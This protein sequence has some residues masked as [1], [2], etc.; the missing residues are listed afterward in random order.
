MHIILRQQDL[1]KC[2]NHLSRNLDTFLLLFFTGLTLSKLHQVAGR[3]SQISTLASIFIFFAPISPPVFPCLHTQDNLS[4]LTHLYKSHSTVILYTKM[5]MY[6]CSNIF[7]FSFHCSAYLLKKELKHK[8][9][10]GV[11]R[12]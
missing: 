3:T 1:Y 12:S 8:P 5:H 9:F 7:A 2:L 10:I 6:V 11:Q 4:L